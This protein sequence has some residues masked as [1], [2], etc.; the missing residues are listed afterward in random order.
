[1]DKYFEATRSDLD[2]NKQDILR[3]L[4]QTQAENMLVGKNACI[5]KPI[6]S[7][8]VQMDIPDAVYFDVEEVAEGATG[9]FKK[10]GFFNVQKSMKKYETGF[11]VTHEV[12]A[13][14]QATSQVDMSLDRSARGL[15]FRKDAEIFTTLA[16]GKGETAAAAALWDAE[17]ADPASDIASA[18]GRIMDGTYI[19][20][21]DVKNIAVY[22]PAKMWTQLAKPIDVNGIIM[23]LR[24]WAESEYKISLLPTRQL[25]TNALVVVKSSETAIHFSYNGKDIPLA[26]RREDEEGEK[27][28]FRDYFITAII[29]ET[30]GG[31]TTKR[32]Q[33]ITGVSS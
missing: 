9:G 18:I 25:L 28:L 11:T 31:T 27:Y 5:M 1:M 13:R 24:A 22:Y 29:P 23:T 20:D 21:E 6:S 32:I 7:L 16:A 12:K 26:F 8:D 33:E 30:S 15:A 3:M 10:L 4:I 14:Q 19:T 2:I 17:E